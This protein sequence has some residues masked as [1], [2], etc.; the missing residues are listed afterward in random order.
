MSRATSKAQA[1]KGKAPARV[2][3]LLT[4]DHEEEDIIP[5]CLTH[6]QWT[7]MLV[8]EEAEDVVGEIMADIMTSVMEAC[9]NVHIERQLSSFT[10]YW[11]KC[12]FTQAVEKK[13]ICRDKGE[14]AMVLS[15]T[16]DP[17]PLPITP[18]V[19]AEGCFPVIHGTLPCDSVSASTQVNQETNTSP[20]FEFTHPEENTQSDSLPETSTSSVQSEGKTIP[21]GHASD[22]PPSP[23]PIISTKKKQ[24]PSLPQKP[25][26]TAL[27]GSRPADK[28]EYTQ[29]PKATK[30]IHKIK[31]SSLPQHLITPQYEIDKCTKSG[32]QTTSG[33]PKLKPLPSKQQSATLQ[34]DQ[35]ERSQVS[36]I[37]DER[38]MAR[39][40]RMDTI[41]LAKGVFLTDPWRTQMGPQQFKS[42]AQFARL[43][44][45]NNES[46]KSAVKELTTGHPPQ[47]TQL[48]PSDKFKF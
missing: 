24:K 30:P 41:N 42:Q 40:L 39:A 4:H 12:Y 8:Q 27:C 14:D 22:K 18:D 25:R 13:I 46:I 11:A 47:V 44:P 15:A 35:P 26:S 16:E 33:Q 1:D 34:S 7:D 28:T 6:G 19:W 32:I 9:Y 2:S 43:R 10:A 31:Q 20:D 29:P 21:Y 5:G 37:K 48:L 36:P 23:K 45:I 17:E 3:P 38:M